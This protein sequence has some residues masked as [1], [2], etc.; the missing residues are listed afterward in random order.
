MTRN[1][2][3]STICGSIIV[4]VA[5]A[6]KVRLAESSLQAAA[7]SKHVVLCGREKIVDMKRVTDKINELNEK[8]E[9]FRAVAVSQ[10]VFET[11]NRSDMRVCV[12]ASK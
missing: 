3:L 8:I 4:I 7:L 2:Y 12:T 6:C 1:L 5:F 10:P 9:E 11:E